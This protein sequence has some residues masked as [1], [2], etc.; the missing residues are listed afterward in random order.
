MGDNSS[1]KLFVERQSGGI[2]FIIQR[3]KREVVKGS[4]GNIIVAFIVTQSSVWTT[5]KLLPPL[6]E[7]NNQLINPEITSKPGHILNDLISINL[8]VPYHP[9]P[10]LVVVSG[11]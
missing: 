4:G 7:N 9:P 3:K 1:A 5:P 10:P 6:R 2:P 11:H 8:I